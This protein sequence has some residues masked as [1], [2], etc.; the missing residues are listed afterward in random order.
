MFK[1]LSLLIFGFL[2]FINRADASHLMGGEITWTCQGSG[3][4]IFTMKLYR[5]CNG[6][7]FSS[8]V[9]LDVSN[10]PGLTTITL[11][12]ISQIEIS[13]VCNAAGPA[14]T[15][16]NAISQPNWP[17]SST[18][19]SGAA[20]ECTYQSAPITLS[21]VPPP[22]GWIFSYTGCC[23][24]GLISNLQTPSGYGYTL[25]AIMHSFNGQNAN[26][27]F[28]SSPRFLELP[29]TV[30]CLGNAFT[31]NHNASDPE[32]DSLHYSWAQPL[33][34]Y[35]GTFNPPGNPVPVPFSSGYTFN[36]PL[37]GTSQNSSNIPAVINPSTGEISFTSY[38]Q[39]SFITVIK[40]EAWKCGQLVGE[41]YREMQMVLLPCGSNSSP[42]VAFTSYADT[43][44]AGDLVSFT[45]TASDPGF[46]SDGI[47]PQTISI[48]ASGSQF[49]TAYTNAS[50][51]C[52]N[53][54]CATLSPAPPLS[55]PASAAIAFN[56]QTACSHLTYNSICNTHSNTYTFVFKSKDDFCPSPA[57]RISTVSITVL[58]NIV[59]SPSPKCV[60]V[61]PSGN[62]NLTWAVPSDT[63][64]SF[65]A[66]LIYTSSSLSGPYTLL[67]SV[68]T[69][70]Q[71]TYTH[72]G[73]NANS[74]VRYYYIRTRSGCNGQFLS[75][76]VDTVRSMLLNVSNPGNGTAVLNWNAI[77]SP[78][79]GSSS[80]VYKIYNEYPAGVWTLTGSTSNLAF[81]DTIFICSASINYR[82][83]ISDNSGCVSVSSVDG[84]SFQNRIV[85]STPIIDTLSVDDNNDAL[86][87]WN[88][89]PSPDAEAY[90][91]YGF[92]SGSW[93][94]IDTV[95][96]INNVSFTNTVS[97]AGSTAEEYLLV[98]LDSC[99]NASPLGDPLK[100]IHLDA[101]ADICS[102]SAILN[103]NAY[104]TIGSGLAGYRIYV[105]TISASGPYTLWGTVGPTV[106][107]YTVS[108]LPPLSNYYFKVT[109]F[110][111]SGTKT[112]SSNRYTFYSGTPVAPQY[113]YLRKVSVSDPD[114]VVIT[115]HIDTAS[116]TKSYKILRSADTVSAN[117]ESV[118]SIPASN[119]TPVV[120]T[121]MNVFTDKL[122]YYYKVV[123]V[124]SCGY[125]GLT[126]NIGRTILAQGAGRSDLTNI[127][128]WNQYEDWS[129]NVMS[130]N[131]YRGID[132]VFDPVPIANV[133]YDNSG[134]YSYTDDISMISS[135]QGVFSYY[136]E[137]LE[138]MGNA[139]GFSEN[140]T[141]NITEA[142]Q[143][144]EVYIPNAFKPA[145]LNNIFIPVTNYIDISDYEF[146]VFNR[147]GLKIFSTT[148]VS[149]GWD[150]THKGQKS[151][152]GVYVYLL[153]FKT[154]RGNYIER[155]G[156]VTLIR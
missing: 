143:E 20:Q 40:V 77:A 66:Y 137:A 78:L 14:I 73:A 145:G 87:S 97:A 84:G 135:G 52:S 46:L 69:L 55:S 28:D 124:D 30:I 102:R 141:S 139:Y 61:L 119:T 83:E 10:F 82:V 27:C 19:V 122:S 62:V 45:L 1:K 146:D 94:P 104:S 129:G 51:G 25:R 67:D 152:V 65:N 140:S 114:R 107:T 133:L 100:T 70:S 105:S 38:T 134:S 111:A 56:W 125:D 131:I 2:L 156:S 75:P 148:D 58:A 110:D 44:L 115:C 88:I 24:N 39:G 13:P 149:Q 42:S 11:N 68:F 8:A 147:W 23:R 6:N 121:D 47:T 130:Y 118:G 99:G 120:F 37:P 132:G 9:N 89:N 5:D 21:G 4:Y 92:S 151:G 85:P 22:A 26:P 126:T 144:A 154:S 95:Y 153:R 49:G 101:E 34:D 113:S 123:N 138:G 74:A 106:L 41:I 35:T 91:V 31:Y 32:L 80:G 103:W 79:P 155:K 93:L 18:P 112:A 142:Y 12:L 36:N 59:A 86:L 64:S 48:S 33:D 72:V 16:A 96:G 17:A 116:S 57:E 29:S 81:V 109:A 50:A 150:G 3:Q 15:C 76:A 108:P 7:D 60:S 90:V 43:V 98:A 128:T 54:P 136:V 53:P 63:G 127:I 117:F 71:N